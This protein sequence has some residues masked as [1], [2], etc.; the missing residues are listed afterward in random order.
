MHASSTAEFYD[1]SV[2]FIYRGNRQTD[3]Q[4][5]KPLHVC[6]RIITITAEAVVI[7]IIVRVLFL[8]TYSLRY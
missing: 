2:V 8:M 5:R 1:I 4:S 6:V 7:I 3:I